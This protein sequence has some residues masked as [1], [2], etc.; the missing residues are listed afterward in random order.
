MIVCASYERDREVAYRLEAALLSMQFGLSI[1]ARPCAPQMLP[2]VRL[3]PI[4]NPNPDATLK[5]VR[6]TTKPQSQNALP[7]L[8]LPTV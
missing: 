4:L 1:C 3:F 2:I 7:L 6:I 5:H 8:L